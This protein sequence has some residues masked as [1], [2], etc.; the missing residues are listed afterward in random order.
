M[1]GEKNE[2]TVDNL[3]DIDVLPEQF[4]DCE[5]GRM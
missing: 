3:S 1:E 2:E 5:P 4:C